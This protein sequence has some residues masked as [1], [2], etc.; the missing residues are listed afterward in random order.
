MQFF[1]LY[2]DQSQSSTTRLRQLLVSLSFRPGSSNSESNMNPNLK[3]CTE[4]EFSWKTS[5]PSSSTTLTSLILILWES[6]NS[7]Q[8]PKNNLLIHILVQLSQLKVLFKNNPNKNL[9]TLKILTGLLRALWLLL[10]TKANVGHVGLSRQ[11]VA[12]KD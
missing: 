12:L 7:Q 3:K 1:L 5:L 2:L 6:I 10:K 11:L 8:W 9:L 4:K